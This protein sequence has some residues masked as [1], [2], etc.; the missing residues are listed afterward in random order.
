MTLTTNS[1]KEFQRLEFLG[2][3]ILN[4]IIAEYLYRHNPEHDAGKLTHQLRFTSNDNL[5]E[6]LD[7]LDAGFRENLV[8]FKSQYKPD[9]QNISADDVEAYIGSFFLQNGFEATRKYIE[10]NL[11]AWIDL[12]DPGTDYKSQLNEFSQQIRKSQPFYE[13]ITDHTT[14][15]NRHEF[16]VRVLIGKEEFGEGSGDKKVRAEQQAAHRALEKVEMER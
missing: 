4:L 13:V 15:D 8:V 5:D 16:H 7:Q 10:Q 2:D 11:G 9:A 3:R 1:T 12:Y 6:I 14:G